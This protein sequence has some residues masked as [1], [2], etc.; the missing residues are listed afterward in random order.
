MSDLLLH[1]SPGQAADGTFLDVTPASAGW[2]YVGFEALALSPGAV[3][4]RDTRDREVCVVVISGTI[5]VS[6]R[7]G[8]WGDVGGRPDPWSG[9]PD[10]AYL[11]PGTV[12]SVISDNGAEVA[13]CWGPAPG[14]GAR[15]RVLPGEKLDSETRGYG[16]LERTIYPILMD[17]RKADSL[18]VCEVRTPG[19][20]W[21]SYPPHK[22]DRADPRARRS[23][24]RPTTT[25]SPPSAASASSVSTATTALWTNRWP[26]VTETACWCRAATTPSRRL[27]GMTC[28]T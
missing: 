10:A 19:G 25:A 17:D 27:P 16:G 23:W 8:E 13:F 5:S 14:G 11:P 3:A 21:S 12:F 26:S 18:L 4:E 20:H 28:I 9:A 24:R 6:S 22:H 1:P 15:A 7:H 2:K